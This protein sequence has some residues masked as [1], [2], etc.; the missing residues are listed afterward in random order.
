MNGTV[1][2]TYKIVIS[3]VF[4][5]FYNGNYKYIAVTYTDNS[6]ILPKLVSS[7]IRLIDFK[8]PH[9]SAYTLRISGTWGT[10]CS[11]EPWNRETASTVCLHLGFGYGYSTIGP[12]TSQYMWNGMSYSYLSVVSTNLSYYITGSEACGALEPKVI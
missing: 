12:H 6:Y 4:E 8:D 10:A 3:G 2:S 9:F 5:V 7:I 11:P 1:D